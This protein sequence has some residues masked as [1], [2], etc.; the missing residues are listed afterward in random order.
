M[1]NSNRKTLRRKPS[2]PRSDFPLY[3]H[4]AGRWAKKVRGRT[5]YF[6]KWADDPKGKEALEEWLDQKDDL[7]AGREPRAHTDKLS[8]AELCNQFLSHK[9]GER[10]NKEISPRTFVTYYGACESLCKV[11]GKNRSVEDLVP[12][13]FRKLKAKLEKTRKAVALRNAMQRV[14]SIFKFAFDDGLVDRQVRFGKGFSKPKLHVIRRAREEHRTQYGDRM[15]EAADIRLMLDA[16]D[17]KAVALESVDKKTDEPARVKLK[18]N[19]QL[20]A[21]ILLGANCAF[22]QTDISSLPK[23]AVDLEKGWIDFPRPKTAVPRKIPLWPETIA[24]I[25]ELLMLRPKA[26]D[27]DDAGLLFL[28]CRG[29][30]WLKVNA[31]TGS[32]S[33][34]IGQEFV[35]VLNKLGLKRSRVSFYALRH[36]FETIA[37]ETVDQVAVDAIMGHVAKG[38]AGVYRER[39][40]DQRL[41]DVV[42]FVRKWLFE[43]EK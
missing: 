10:D 33:D 19:P 6:T 32:H 11:L 30:R 40:S 16:L 5:I 36:G 15:F 17:G 26:K 35:K 41:K 12:D 39:I 7:L 20:K 1:A 42:D 23:R 28:T 34:A 24:A 38:M 13:D 37:G 8:V 3:A 18:P 2:K 4:A 25:R 31:K 43:P 9:E 29:T 22:G 21:M 27:K 14:R